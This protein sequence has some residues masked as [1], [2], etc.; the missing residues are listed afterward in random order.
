M[1]FSLA[2]LDDDGEE[3]L[4]NVNMIDEEVAEKNNERKLKK[5]EYNPYDDGEEGGLVSR[6]ISDIRLLCFLY[7][8]F[9]INKFHEISV[10]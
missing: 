1:T 8:W 7:A 2:I 9:V 4:V 3:V 5:P 10:V 6:N